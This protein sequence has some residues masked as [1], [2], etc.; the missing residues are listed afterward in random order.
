MADMPLRATLASA[1]FESTR[2][3]LT[4]SEK[5]LQ[6]S[7]VT[8]INEE[9]PKQKSNRRFLQ[10]YMNWFAAETLYC[11][12]FESELRKLPGTTLQTQVRSK[13]VYY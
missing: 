7:E 5:L 4:A 6:L 2:R 9:A 10:Y 12:E 3:V 8:R 11:K 1:T 13:P